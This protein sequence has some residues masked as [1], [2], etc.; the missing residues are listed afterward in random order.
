[1][2]L[3]QYIKLMD[4]ITKIYQEK[5]IMCVNHLFEKITMRKINNGIN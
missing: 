2:W 4:E 1:M 3:L 5:I